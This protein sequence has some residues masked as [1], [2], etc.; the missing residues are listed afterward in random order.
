MADDF[1]N[2][3]NEI[4]VDLWMKENY[5][6]IERQDQSLL[7][8]IPGH[9]S[10]D[11]LH[12]FSGNSLTFPNSKVCVCFPKSWDLIGSFQKIM[13]IQGEIFNMLL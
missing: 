1:R 8:Q 5:S 12:N 2:S 10:E 6:T 7:H 3:G 9:F 4:I 13:K 11:W